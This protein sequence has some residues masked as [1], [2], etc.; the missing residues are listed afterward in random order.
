M[1]NS[2]Q[3]KRILFLPPDTIWILL[4]SVDDK[5]CWK[6]RQN[7]QWSSPLFSQ[8]KTRT[9]SQELIDYPLQ[10]CDD[11][12]VKIQKRWVLVSLG[13]MRSF[14]TWRERAFVLPK[15]QLWALIEQLLVPG[16]VWAIFSTG[17]FRLQQQTISRPWSQ[18]G[19]GDVGKLFGRLPKV[20]TSP[21]I[22]TRVPVDRCD[23][24]SNSVDGNHQTPR[25]EADI[26]LR[27]KGL[28][29]K[30]MGQPSSV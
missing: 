22:C 26:E 18:A 21:A 10:H 23:S 25:N 24:R 16:Y 9:S 28:S 7:F 11:K 17:S 2:N 1:F 13:I 19:E 5:L 14:H 27:R 8:Q 20:S 3:W 4:L 6:Q 29:T 15:T 12:S 30:T